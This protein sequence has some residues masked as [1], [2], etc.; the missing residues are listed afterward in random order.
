MS[1]HDPRWTLLSAAAR[2]AAAGEAVS[3]PDPAWVTRVAALG[4]E[5]VRRYRALP[6]W[7]AW[8]T[9]ALGVAAVIAVVAYFS[10]QPAVAVPH[11]AE[12][13]VVLVDPLAGGELFP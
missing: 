12:Q 6:P 13:L 11:D 7:L 1:N 4:A 9:P 8:T 5:L 10:L 2:R 3:A